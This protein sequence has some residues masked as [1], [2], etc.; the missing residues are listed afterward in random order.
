MVVVDDVADA[1]VVVV[2]PIVCVAT[3]NANAD[4]DDARSDFDVSALCN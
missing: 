1:F 2:A 3:A 4:V